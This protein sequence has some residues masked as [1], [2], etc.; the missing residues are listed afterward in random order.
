LSIKVI[1]LKSYRIETTLVK[2]I[3]KTQPLTVATKIENLMIKSLP[4]HRGRTGTYKRV[5]VSVTFKIKMTNKNGEEHVSPSH[6]ITGTNNTIIRN[7]V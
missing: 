3:I 4:K 7:K 1:L 6:D 5:K 2:S